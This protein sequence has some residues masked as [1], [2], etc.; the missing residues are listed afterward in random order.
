MNIANTVESDNSF[1]LTL[2]ETYKIHTNEDNNGFNTEWCEICETRANEIRSGKD[3]T[4][5]KVLLPYVLETVKQNTS[6][7]DTILD[8]GSGCGFLTSKIAEMRNVQGIDISCKA[9][10]HSKNN[11]SQ[12]SFFQGD[13]RT[14]KLPQ[15]YNFAVAN[16]V[17]HN[18]PDL[19]AF[20]RNV[21][22]MLKYNGTLL[23]VIL[24][25][26]YWGSEKLKNQGFVYN[27]S[28]VYLR[29]F[30]NIS[31]PIKYYHR[32]IYEYASAIEQSGLELWNIEPIYEEYDNVCYQKYPHILSIIAKRKLQEST[33][34]IS[35]PILSDL[36]R[37]VL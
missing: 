29:K 16:M 33:T 37:Q 35:P 13:I 30:K 24:H 22:N 36:R 15:S 3:K 21:H 4:Y 1:N 31:K 7:T 32:P 28:K 25:P 12:L 20:F 8:I 17:V 19:S 26:F 9:I 6:L 14:I 23:I 2:N 34:I 5:N 11:Y 18:L 10:E 27:E